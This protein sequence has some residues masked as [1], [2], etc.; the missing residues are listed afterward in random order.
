VSL[1]AFVAGTALVVAFAGALT[2]AAVEE[3]RLLLPG[4][5]GARARLAEAV[6]GVAS[7]VLLAQVLG[8][9]GQLRR[10]PLV[11]G[12]VVVAAVL[13]RARRRRRPTPRLDRR[14][15]EE[16]AAG[17]GAI[18]V[19]VCATAFA[20]TM[21]LQAALDALHDGMRSFD[22][23]WY[24]MPFAAR[25]AQDGWVTHL[26]YVGNGPTTFYPANGELVHAVGIV[27]FGSDV[28]SPL[29]NVGWLAL[30]LLAGWCVGQRYGAAPATL[31]ATLVV[32]L[33]PVM[34]AAQVGSAGTDIPMLALLVASVALWLA[35]PTSTPALVFAAAAAGVAVGTKLNAWAP[36]LALGCVVVATSRGRRARSG[37]IWGG[38]IL[39][40]SGMWYLRNAVA[41]GNPFPWFHRWLVGIALPSTTAPTDCGRTSVAH[42]LTD[43]HVVWSWLVPQLT[44]ALGARWWLIVLLAFAGTVAG[45]CVGDSRLRGLAVVAF[46][47]GAAYLLTPATA[48]GRSAGCFSYNT[49]FA[50][51]AIVLGLLLL[52]LVLARYRRGADVAVVLLALALAA[53]RHGSREWVPVVGVIFIGISALAATRASARLDRR[54]VAVVLLGVFVIS[55]VALRHEEELYSN[56]RWAT[57]R[58]SDPIRPIIPLIYHALEARVAVVGLAENYPFYGKDLSNRVEYPARRV[59]A[60]FLA[61]PTCVAW[62]DALL[63]GGY[64]YVVTA[65]QSGGAPAAAV[66]TSRLPG[67]RRLA[68]SPHRGQPWTWQVFRLDGRASSE[69]G[70][71]VVPRGIRRG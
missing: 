35:E 62:N 50:A 58:F 47:S 66:W 30:A 65:R 39:V 6:G 17:V 67:A 56:Q 70:C 36:L 19:A 55:A 8:G 2:L 41:V 64:D 59:G 23:L 18:G 21:V 28:L 16:T 43:P 27:L 33:L 25:F 63:S 61:Y 12:A 15:D 11:A 48:G 37:A 60:R 4:W 51:P 32:A 34:G 49:R 45:L 9:V 14:G 7:L 71:R 44:G 5:T 53:T 52:P 22:T 54:L 26:H 3:R 38:G 46:L 40:L 24:H 31:V 57:T 20:A 1:G 10:W 29:V 13:T 42:Y 68:A 69:T